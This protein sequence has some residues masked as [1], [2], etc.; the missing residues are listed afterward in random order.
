MQE[1]IK[2]LKQIELRLKKNKFYSTKEMRDVLNNIVTKFNEIDNN[3]VIF[4]CI[5]T[6]LYTLRRILDKDYIKNILTYNGANHVQNMVN[7]LINSFNFNLLGYYNIDA[8]PFVLNKNYIKNV[9]THFTN[10]DLDDKY[11][12]ENQCINIKKLIKFL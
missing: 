10:Y 8:F 6:D 12:L 3:L 4:F 11:L 7:I 9:Y 5:F 2:I 1:F